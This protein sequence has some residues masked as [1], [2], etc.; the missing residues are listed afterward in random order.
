MLDLKINNGVLWSIFD[1]FIDDKTQTSID[2]LNL[3]LRLTKE[4]NIYSIIF[5]CHQ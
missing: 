1:L 3:G 2:Q 5:L 4:K